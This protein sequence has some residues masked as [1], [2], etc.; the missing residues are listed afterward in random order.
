MSNPE[1]QLAKYKEASFRADEMIEA[2][3]RNAELQ[4]TVIEML[5]KEVDRL[6]RL[7]EELRAVI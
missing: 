3:Q 2:L 5:Q 1:V 4:Q 6:E 7:I